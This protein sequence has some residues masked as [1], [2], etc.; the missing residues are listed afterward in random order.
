M[1]LNDFRSIYFPYCL[2]KQTDGA[3]VVLNREYKP[4]GFNTHDFVKYENYPVATKFKGLGPATL[5]KLDYKGCASG[6]TVFL[7]NDGCVPTHNAENMKAYMKKLQL[8]AKLQVD[9]KR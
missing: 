5:D 9:T 4:V 6:D 1:P 2:K 3:W 7:Y 8:L